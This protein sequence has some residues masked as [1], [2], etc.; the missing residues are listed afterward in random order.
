MEKEIEQLKEKFKPFVNSLEIE[1]GKK[2]STV[3]IKLAL[4]EIKR[5]FKSR[6]IAYQIVVNLL[7]I[8]YKHKALFYLYPARS[9]QYNDNKLR[10]FYHIRLGLTSAMDKEGYLFY[11]Y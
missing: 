9:T 3:Y 11:F 7:Q 8:A 2:G 4:L 5:L 10:H 1:V 6:K